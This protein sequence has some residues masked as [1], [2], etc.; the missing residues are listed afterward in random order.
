MS[1]RREPLTDG[2]VTLTPVPDEDDPQHLRF[3]VEAG[4]AVVGEVSLLLLE[5]LVGQLTWSTD[6]QQRRRGMATRAVRL[7]TRHAITELRLARVQAYVDPSDVASL[8]I[9]GRSGLRREGVLRG[10]RPNTGLG[11]GHDDG[12]RGGHPDHGDPAR[13]EHPDHGG[14][15]PGGHPDHGDQVSGESSGLG[16]TGRTDLVVFA[17]LADDPEPHEPEG[18]RALLN[19]GLPRK[20]VISQLAIRDHEDRLLLCQL[21]YK[22]D[23][24]LPGGV[25]EVGESPRLAAAREVQEELALTVDAGDLLLV[26]WLPAWSGWDDACT[27]VFDGGVHAAGLT[28]SIVPEPREIRTAEFCDADQIRERCA[29]QTVRRALAALDSTQGPLRYLESGA[30]P[31]MPPSNTP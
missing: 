12:A 10:L 21:S 8:R 19:A 22:P 18:F 13:G 14:Q 25:V 4:S 29:P 5:D 23:W 1:R 15:P 20:R 3:R 31:V 2:T 17:R 6:P 24:D 30:P 7:L 26:D 27:L 11:P 9:A 28:D 16:D